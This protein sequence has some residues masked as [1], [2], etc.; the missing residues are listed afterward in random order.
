MTSGLTWYD[1][2]AQEHGL[3]WDEQAA[4]EAVAF[5][6]TYIVH[7]KGAQFAKKPFR[8][9]P[10]QLPTTRCV[11]GWKM[12][13]GGPRAIQKVYEEI[14]R[15]NGKSTK[16]SGVAAKGLMADGEFGPEV[17]GAAEDKDQ[18]S[19][20]WGMFRDMVRFGPRLKE[21][22]ARGDLEVVPSGKRV[23]YWPNAGTYQ[24]IPADAA[25]SFGFNASTCVFDEFHVQ[26]DRAL[27]EA[28]RTSMAARLSPLMWIFT[29]AGFDFD[30]VC[31]EIHEYALRILRREIVDL[32]FLPVVYSAGLTPDWREIDIVADGSW[33]LRDT[34]LRA[35]PNLGVTVQERFLADL[36]RE[37]VEMPQV[38]NDFLRLHCNV[39]TRQ[40]TRWMPPDLWL[41][42]GTGLEREHYAGRPAY[43]GI[44]LA[45][46]TDI[47]A[48]GVVIPPVGEFDE[49][50]WVVWHDFFLPE[51]TAMERAKKDD[52]RYL[53]WANRGF[54][55]LTRGTATDYG[56]IERKVREYGA[57]LNVK[58][59]AVDP[60]Q[61]E[62]MAQRLVAQG[63]EVAR[64][65]NTPQHMNEGMT[66]WMRISRARRLRH[67]KSPVMSSMV[68]NLSVSKDADGRV[69]PDRKKS[70]QKIDGVV[71]MVL[72]LVRAHS[73]P[74]AEE[75]PRV[76]RAA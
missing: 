27:Y 47:A 30:T 71:A 19:I 35:N 9:A 1:E 75:K 18:A 59:V 26:P 34:W 15:K 20:I 28:L 41:Q 58:G 56:A 72:G 43:L 6:E 33:K 12:E 40:E 76:W 13:K 3:Y 69:K 14:G 55:D 48:I 16:G 39:W 73:A 38:L 51:A 37:A 8:F 57:T 70:R 65:P 42:C 66:Q 62:Y 23:V 7:V 67:E 60:W 50:E 11:Y 4:Q 24:A 36:A 64:I 52:R 31:Y 10:W 32:S 29:T 5:F 54:L 44:D 21:V 61:A 53:D 2:V 68:D 74:Q 25:G 46:T 45:T 63:F 49:G 22:E 17:Y